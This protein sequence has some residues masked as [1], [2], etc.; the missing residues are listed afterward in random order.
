MNGG[1]RRKR[2]ALPFLPGDGTSP[3]TPSPAGRGAAGQDVALEGKGIT[4]WRFVGVQPTNLV[5]AVAD[6]AGM[7]AFEVRELPILRG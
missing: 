6:S 2:G 4:G 1:D 5:M 3:P 7:R